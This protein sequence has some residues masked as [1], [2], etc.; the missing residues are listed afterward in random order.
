M[1]AGDFDWRTAVLN[2]INTGGSVPAGGVTPQ[3]R[4]LYQP[5]APGASSLMKSGATTP[6]GPG[7]A[8]PPMPPAKPQMGASP[9]VES[10]GGQP[11]APAFDP[12]R[13]RLVGD[14]PQQFNPFARRF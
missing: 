2:A 3:R 5:P 6:G 9:A 14:R 12:R 8:P 1:A 4:G 10:V 11:T 13:S 7:A